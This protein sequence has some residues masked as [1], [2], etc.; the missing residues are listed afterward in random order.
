MFTISLI[1]SSNDLELG[2]YHV[3]L[4]PIP[5]KICISQ[6]RSKQQKPILDLKIIEIT[7]VIEPWLRFGSHSDFET[8]LNKN[9]VFWMYKLSKVS[10]KEHLVCEHLA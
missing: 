7:P 5:I 1:M 10:L 6:L 3:T 2:R 4:I 8:R 9:N